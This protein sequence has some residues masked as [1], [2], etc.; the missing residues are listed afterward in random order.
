MADVQPFSA[1]RYAPDLDLASAICPPYDTI[2]PDQQ[3]ALHQRAPYNAVHIELAEDGRGDRYARAAAT[4]D[5]WRA[6]GTV[7]RDDRPAFYLCRQRFEHGGR[8]YTRSLLFA[9]LRLEPWDAGVVLPHEQTFGGPKADRLKLLRA[10]H[11]NASPVFLIYRDDDAR[12]AR[13]LEAAQ[14]IPP[15]ADFTADDGQHHTL[16]RIDDP[17]AAAALSDVFSG[18]TLYVAD[19]HHRYETALAYR[20]D[21]RAATGRWTGDEPEN[22]ALVALAAAGDPGLL[23]LPIHRVTAAATP[24]AE[25]LARLR[26]LFRVQDI[27]P[28]PLQ[29]VAA[30]AAA[31]EGAFGLATAASPDLH[32]LTLADAAAV[33]AILPPDRSPEWRRLDYAIA[34][35]AILRHGLGL[36]EAQMSDHDVLWFTADAGEAVQSVRSGAAGHAVLLNPV[37]VV[38]ILA[39]AGSGER[40]PQKSTFFYPKVPTGLVFNLLED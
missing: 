34:N 5:G 14:D 15:I 28:D 26:K 33:D 21:C 18:R 11:L 16:A 29:I 31:G 25:A 4:L 8:T 12:V 3:R 24:S 13:A 6:G 10:T 39:M 36:T 19:G 27:G 23:V 20:D 37:P 22:F 7:R 32:L 17:A 2:S 30:L 38:R 1:L 40:M 35:Y 9:R